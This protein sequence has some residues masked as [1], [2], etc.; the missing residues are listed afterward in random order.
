MNVTTIK[1]RLYTTVGTSTYKQI[2]WI[3]R[4][5]P[6]CQHHLIEGSGE[7]CELPGEFD[8]RLKTGP[9]GDLCAKHVEAHAVLNK[10][11]GFHRISQQPEGEID[12]N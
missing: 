11:M 1:G 2:P 7:E 3:S 8:A 4:R 6:P 10:N 12:A 5:M 9:W